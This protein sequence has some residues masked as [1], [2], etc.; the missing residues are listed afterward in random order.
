M[1]PYTFYP[2][3]QP[4]LQDN[5]YPTNYNGLYTIGDVG[6]NNSRRLF[7]AINYVNELL[8]ITSIHLLIANE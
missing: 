5:M 2:H 7:C 3:M 6:G 8:Y 1:I 4:F